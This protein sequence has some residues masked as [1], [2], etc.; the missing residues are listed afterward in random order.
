MMTTIYPDAGEQLIRSVVA[1]GDSD[2]G[3]LFYEKEHTNQIPEAE[4]TN[5][6]MKNLLLIHYSDAYYR[7]V[8]YSVSA[9]VGTAVVVEGT[10]S[11]ATFLTFKTKEA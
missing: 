6:V 2:N 3:H 1:Y 11:T 5:L 10:G 9:S 8:K 7:P 4:I